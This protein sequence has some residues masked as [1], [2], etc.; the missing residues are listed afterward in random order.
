M[1]T[2]YSKCIHEIRDTLKSLESLLYQRRCYATNLSSISG[3]K[4][5]VCSQED[6][7]TLQ[8]TKLI[9]ED[10]VQTRDT[11]THLETANKL[12]K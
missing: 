9:Q 2:T 3:S 7:R 5:G 6:D 4:L 10:Q 1:R 11:Y 8:D 12:E